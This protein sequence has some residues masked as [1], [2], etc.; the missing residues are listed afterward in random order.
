MNLRNTGDAGASVVR[1]VL[2]TLGGTIAFG[3]LGIV[4]AGTAS[5]QTQPTAPG[6]VVQ[7]GVGQ[8]GA[9]L[10][11][12]ITSSARQALAPVTGTSV[13][14]PVTTTAAQVLKPVTTTA[15]QALK[16]VTTVA[17]QVLAPVTRTA[18]QVS[19]PVTHV[20][21]PVVTTTTRVLA[22]VASV[23]TQVLSPVTGVVTKPVFPVTEPAVPQSLG[24]GTSVSAAAAK[25]FAAPATVGQS[26]R[27]TTTVHSGSTYS[28]STH[29]D[30][31]H[32]GSTMTGRRP[33]T[34][35]GP[36]GVP[37][38]PV[39]PSNGLLAG[40]AGTTSAGGGQSFGSGHGLAADQVSVRPAGDPRLTAATSSTRPLCWRAFGHNHPS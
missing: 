26:V 32:G 35:A 33:S 29:G 23:T 12:G 14:T 27:G 38:S 5:A 3:V 28:G 36:S 6:T 30:S 18:A 13:L 11:A 8:N 1:R 34:I 20:L 10:P 9:G 31:T 39:N 40:M 4:L 21:A 19:Q 17:T 2:L 7:N 24:V 37:G 22:P 16:P 25:P 15:S